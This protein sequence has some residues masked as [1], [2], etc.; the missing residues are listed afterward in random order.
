MFISCLRLN[1]YLLILQLIRTYAQNDVTKNGPVSRAQTPVSQPSRSTSRAPTPAA[2]PSRGRAP[3]PA[4]QRRAPTPAAQS[5]R[6]TSRAPT[7]VA[8]GTSRAPT[9]TAQAP[10]KVSQTEVCLY[11]LSTFY[12]AEKGTQRRFH[13]LR[14]TTQSMS[15]LM[16]R[17]IPFQPSESRKGE[18][19]K[20]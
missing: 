2:Q 13:A 16:M 1:T 9:S 12:S 7:P 20:M 11:L 6:S 3:A 17:R 15:Q 4:A 10:R 8:R 19:R 14:M 5:S 18:R